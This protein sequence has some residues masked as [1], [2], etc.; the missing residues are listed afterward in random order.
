VEAGGL[1]LGQENSTE[2]LAKALRCLPE[3]V[4]SSER[5]GILGGFGST[6]LL[7]RIDQCGE[8]SW[9]FRPCS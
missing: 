6:A 4:G 2:Y 3:R 5:L 8:R 9:Q 1:R 7:L